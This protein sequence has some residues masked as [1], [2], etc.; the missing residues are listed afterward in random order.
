MACCG[1]Q[2]SAL[3]HG[4]ATEG[5]EGAVPLEFT[6]RT[7]IVVRGPVTGRG[8]RFHDGA[9]IQLVDHRD[10]AALIAT[11]YFQQPGS[12]KPSAIT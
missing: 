7:N 2:R 1:Q 8:Y 4:N 6:R 12:A 5:F 9:Y 3:V 11:G 10:A